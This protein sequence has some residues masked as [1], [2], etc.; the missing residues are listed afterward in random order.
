MRKR[1][2]G[3]EQR[4]TTLRPAAHSAV[5]SRSELK[6]RLASQY[7]TA[8]FSHRQAYAE[9]KGDFIQRIVERALAEGH[10]HDS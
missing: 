2:G 6:R 10:P 1:W 8:Q 4:F 7:S 9:A 3:R 5:M